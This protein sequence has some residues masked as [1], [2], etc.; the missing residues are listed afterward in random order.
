MEQE[1]AQLDRPV[2]LINTGGTFNKRYDPLRG[3]LYVPQDDRAIAAIL[4]DF[5]A[6]LRV[7][8]QG[9]IYKDSLAMNDQDRAALAD[10]IHVAEERH[11]L[12]VHGTDTMHL[13]AAYLAQACPGRRIVLTGAMQPYAFY[14][15]EA[16]M[17]LALSMGWLLAGDEAE[18]RIGMH[19]LVLPHAQIIKDR[20]NGIFVRTQAAGG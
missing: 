5:H 13:T 1:T 12:V 2:L 3:E 16:A 17:N 14:A 10:A 9:M 15:Q 8:V 6:N 11:V 18:V 7:R 4:G 19:G 20:Q